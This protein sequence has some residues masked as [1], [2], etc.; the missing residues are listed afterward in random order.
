[1]EKWLHARNIGRNHR[2]LKQLHELE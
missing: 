2:V 1:L